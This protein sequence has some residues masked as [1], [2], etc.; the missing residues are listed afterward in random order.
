[1]RI[2]QTIYGG[3]PRSCVTACAH[4]SPSPHSTNA[5]HV[6]VGVTHVYFSHKVEPAPS[7]PGIAESLGVGKLVLGDH[8]GTKAGIRKI[9]VLLTYSFP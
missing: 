8:S 1:M 3:H 4:V 2:V 6:I 5:I 7:S 9:T